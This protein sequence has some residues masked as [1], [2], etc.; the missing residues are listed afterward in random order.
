MGG[1]LLRI[2]PHL[3]VMHPASEGGGAAFIRRAGVAVH[4]RDGPVV[5]RAGHGIA[6]HDALAQRPALVRAAVEQGEHPVVGGAEHRHRH[7][8]GAGH[9]A[10]TE[11]GDVVAMWKQSG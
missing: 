6:V 3:A 4:Q 5:Q 1:Q 2:Q 7:A 11:R 10:C 8:L 9:P